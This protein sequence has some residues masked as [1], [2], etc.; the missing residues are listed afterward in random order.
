MRACG[1]WLAEHFGPALVSSSLSVV[2]RNSPRP[3]ALIGRD[4]K[5]PTLGVIVADRQRL[6]EHRFEPSPAPQITPQNGLNEWIKG[7]RR[8]RSRVGI[9]R[10][11]GLA[12]GGGQWT[13]AGSRWLE[14]SIKA[15]PGETGG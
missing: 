3:H 9:S 13:V 11:Q 6:I 1:C 2:P 10:I 14:N 15:S 7:S 5:S 4:H 8:R 12:E